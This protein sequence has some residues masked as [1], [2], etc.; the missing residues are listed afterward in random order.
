MRVRHRITGSVGEVLDTVNDVRLPHM[1]GE[2]H[3]VQFDDGLTCWCP[4]DVLDDEND[5]GRWHIVVIDQPIGFSALSRRDPGERGPFTGEWRLLS[6]SEAEELAQAF[7]DDPREGGTAH[8]VE[9]Y[10]FDG[11]P[12]WTEEY[13]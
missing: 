4:D 12:V 9:V 8:V 11:D 7:N 13:A 10:R 1:P 5:E 3:H 6:E 2:W